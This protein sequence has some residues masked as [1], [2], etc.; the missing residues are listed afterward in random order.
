MAL[1]ITLFLTQITIAMS[2]ISNSP[3]VDGMT[4]MSYWM[5][6][7]QLFLMLALLEY[8]IILFCRFVFEYK[9]LP[10]GYGKKQL[11]KLDFAS[12]LISMIS[13]AL[14]VVIFFTSTT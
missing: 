6:T 4:H 13:F 12:L 1:L 14:F 7:C 3:K 2:I 10:K 11:M 8:G 9:S 5:A